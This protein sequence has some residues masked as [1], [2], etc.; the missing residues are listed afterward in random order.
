MARILSRSLNLKSKMRLGS[1][2]IAAS[3]LTAL[4]TIGAAAPIELSFSEPQ[5][6]PVAGAILTLR[7]TD[8]TNPT[9]KAVKAVMDQKN[10]AFMP[11]VVIVPVGS[12]V[13]FPNSD[14]ISHQ[15]YSFSPAKKFQLP[16]YRGNVNPPIVF[17]KPGVVTLGCNI[18]DKMR[19][20]VFVTE[21]PYFGRTDVL[22]KWRSEENLPAGSYT[23][24]FWH[25]LARDTKL[26][27]EQ[28]IRI[29][30]GSQLQQ[31][32]LKSILPVKLREPAQRPPG[33][34]AY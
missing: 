5:G 20:Y 30:P 13:E 15:V 17:D 34:D 24:E 18:H 3:L 31:I 12:T 9:R 14:N 25:P 23:V 26:I 1:H 10:R 19:G 4:S 32:S 27:H 11:H 28:V 22:G 29:E 8:G 16:L 2:V 7:S 33:W 21:S 6:S